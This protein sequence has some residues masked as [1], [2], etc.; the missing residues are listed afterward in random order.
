V[1]R[2]FLDANILFSAAYRSSSP[3]R[4]LW[5]LTDVELF[6]SPFAVQEAQTNLTRARPSQL[7]HLSALLS[8]TTLIADPPPGTTLP[9]GVQLPQ[10][11]APILLSAIDGKST[12]LLTGDV[13]HFGPYFGNTIA[14]VLILRP[15]DYIQSRQ[16]PP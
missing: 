2:V 1:D 4:Q 5:A 6:S 3:L 11:D 8:A 16:P 15:R 10:K 7:P 13:K 14:G 9:A 12:H